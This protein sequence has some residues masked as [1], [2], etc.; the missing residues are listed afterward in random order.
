MWAHRQRVTVVDLASGLATDVSLGMGT[1]D[2]VLSA[3][4]RK[5]KERELR[6]QEATESLLKAEQGLFRPHTVA[7][8]LFKCL[9]KRNFSEN[10]VREKRRS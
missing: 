9:K 7:L 1:W 3:K 2:A 8:P 5:A 10:C 4:C 6:K